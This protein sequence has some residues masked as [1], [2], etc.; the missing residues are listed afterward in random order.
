MLSS[1]AALRQ[2]G[3]L[4][5]TKPASKCITL[6]LESI[7][8]A[9]TTSLWSIINSNVSGMLHTEVY[10]HHLP[11]YR[12]TFRVWNIYCY[13]KKQFPFLYLNLRCCT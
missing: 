7:S 4:E 5:F 12:L 8:V 10:T 2:L 11:L 6:L 3:T 9:Y 13:E 1:V